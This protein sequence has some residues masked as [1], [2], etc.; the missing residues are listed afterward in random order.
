[1]ILSLISCTLRR[2]NSKRR[3]RNNSLLRPYNGSD[4][5]HYTQVIAQ[6]LC[7]K[8]GREATYVF[9]K[10]INN[11]IN[12]KLA[13]RELY[14]RIFSDTF[15]NLDKGYLPD[16]QDKMLISAQV[17]LGGNTK[18]QS[19]M[20][21]KEYSNR[22][23]QQ[24][25]DYLDGLVSAAGG[26]SDRLNGLNDRVSSAAS[27]AQNGIRGGFNDIVSSNMEFEGAASML[28]SLIM[29]VMISKIQ[30][31]I[32][33]NTSQAFS[34]QQMRELSNFDKE[35]QSRNGMCGD[36]R[37]ETEADGDG[38]LSPYYTGDIRVLDNKKKRK[39]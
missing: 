28:F 39:F 15:K 32:L 8:I 14:D 5:D 3:N 25:K 24:N 13:D 7:L 10:N 12:G 20:Y 34:N 2:S 30:Q 1:M 35:I 36:R 9:F 38:L 33:R 6:K 26:A 4:L 16:I 18:V 22:I 17:A 11:Y 19:P 29:K 23:Y 31:K 37:P 21:W 27:F